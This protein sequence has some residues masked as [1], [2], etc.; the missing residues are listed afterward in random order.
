VCYLDI[1]KAFDSV[2]I[3][4]IVKALQFYGVP[5]KFIKLIQ[6]IYQDNEAKAITHF[7]PL[8]FSEE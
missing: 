4:V 2:E 1:K 5:K 6:E 3:S 8:K 7:E